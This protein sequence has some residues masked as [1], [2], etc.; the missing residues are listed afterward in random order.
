MCS[1]MQQVCVKKIKDKSFF[2]KNVCSNASLIYEPNWI[3]LKRNIE[4]HRFWKLISMSEFS[5]WKNDKFG[6][7]KN[8]KTKVSKYR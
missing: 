4:L 1:K 3:F 7:H 6:R 2:T 8:D 5:D